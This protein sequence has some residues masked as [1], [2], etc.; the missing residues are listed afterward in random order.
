MVMKL[1]TP[2]RLGALE[3][4]NRIVMSAMN[5]SRAAD[6]KVP[7]ELTALYYAQRASAGL[8]ITESTNVSPQGSSSFRQPGL[9][10]DTQ[11]AA[12]KRVTEAVHRAGGRIF[13]QLFHAGRQSHVDF[14][15]DNA[16]P[17]APSAIAARVEKR[18]A[19]GEF[20]PLPTP[21]ALETGEIAAI[22]EDFRYACELA[23][24]AG[25]DGVELHGGNGF[26]I[27]QFL[28]SGCNR[29]ND[30]YGGSP[31]KR[32]RFL[33]EVA[34]AAVVEL[35]PGRVGVRLSP[36]K[37]FNDMYDDDPVATYTSAVRLL[38][39]LPMAYVHLTEEPPAAKVE[40]SP[41]TEGLHEILRSEYRGM[42]I[43]NGGYNRERAE[44]DLRSGAA[45]LISFGNYFIS[46]PDLPERFLRN[47]PLNEVDRSTVYFGGAKGY[48]DY[49]SLADEEAGIASTG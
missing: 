10:T 12:W 44:A 4:P 6:G 25:F 47:A 24:D 7:T 42:M 36:R 9:C 1:F 39:D 23:N 20:R 5:R 8:I 41:G 14:Q 48:T 28:R 13:V 15:P 27:E 37:A 45:D 11:L 30:A 34:E 29:R 35:G 19:A 21:R 26:L 3:L 22:V 40:A 32:V 33:I 16:L 18:N 46:N 49:P 17:V 43:L 38:N 2:L 31:D